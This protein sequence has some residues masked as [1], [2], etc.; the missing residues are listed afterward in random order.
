M[1]DHAAALPFD[2]PLEDVYSAWRR[3][4]IAAGHSDRTIDGRIGTVRLLARSG[5]DPLT[6][7]RE[8]LTLWLSTAKS[9]RSGQSVSRSTRATY[10]SQLRA[11]YDWLEDT[12]RRPDDPSSKL[13][14]PR[15]PRGVPR[16]VTP[17]QV[18]DILACCGHRAAVTT[19][20]YVL[21]GAY[22][23]LRVHEIA[24]VRGEDVVG[25]VIFVEGKGG[26]RS[27][28][29]LHPL[30]A[31]LAATMPRRG[32]WFPSPPPYSGHVLRCS[33][34][35]A[36][37]R[38]MDRAGVE[39]TPHALRHHYGTEVLRAS[40]GNLRTAQRALRH[41]SV[42]TTAIYTMVSDETLYDAI[43]GI[44]VSQTGRQE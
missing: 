15:A 37:K 26:S 12:G 29:P 14:K 2:E 41:A 32:W 40:G 4:G 30:L 38:A 1:T 22:A 39:A 28:V 9:A 27:S 20:A 43:A 10:R 19:R 44:R 17:A 13:P 5:V 11:F 23:G 3:H 25:A 24:K 16:P 18:Q 8:D 6:A 21:L 35:S 36:I 33:V 7:T 42:A 31:E 34:S